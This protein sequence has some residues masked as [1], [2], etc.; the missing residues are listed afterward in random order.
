MN[1]S[2]IVPTYNGGEMWNECARA[3]VT[4]S[5]Q[6]QRIM[7]V[8]SSS[9]DN[10][11]S[12]ANDYN[13][14]LKII[15][16]SDFNH[17]GT[18]NFAAKLCANSEVLVFLTQD[19]IFSSEYSLNYILDC[20]KDPA[21]AAVCGR[22]LPHKDAN[23]IAVHARL[24]N[25]PDNSRVKDKSDIESL[26]LRVPFMSNSFAAYRTSALR[27][28][29]GFPD[30]TILAEDMS[31][32]AKMVLSGFKVMYCAEATVFHSHNYT[33]WQEFQRYFDTGVFHSC[34]PWIRE[35][36]GGASS[37]GK[38]FLLSEF[39]YLL[40]N[41]PSWIPRALFTTLCKFAGYKLGL[42]HMFMPSS[43]NRYFSMYKSYWSQ[44]S[45][46]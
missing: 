1:V 9:T 34:E 45:K 31:T 38:K 5:F 39:R 37:E 7:V 20:L 2:L 8:D 23:P 41:A 46:I 10:T 44:Q 27:D 32:A 43:L 19:A 28:I 17:G 36:F 14:E 6:P 33:P 11:Q 26:G 25:Y 29:G 30:N 15:S 40:N 3:I 4:Q 12:V 22:Q 16:S 35:K 42:W 24:F 18:R 13:F 21:I